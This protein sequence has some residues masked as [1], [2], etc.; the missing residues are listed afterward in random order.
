MSDKKN[1]DGRVIGEGSSITLSE[2]HVGKWV[3][4]IILYNGRE[5]KSRPVY[6]HGADSVLISMPELATSFSVD[7][8]YRGEV[9]PYEVTINSETGD[10][11][12]VEACFGEK[13]YTEAVYVEKGEGVTLNFE[14][15]PGNGYMN[16]SVKV[17]TSGGEVL[18][19][20]SDSINFL[21]PLTN[22]YLAP[23]TGKIGLAGPV[24]VD[25][26]NDVAELNTHRLEFTWATSETTKGKY[27]IEFEEDI[28][29][30]HNANTE[31]IAVVDYN[32]KLYNGR[33][34]VKNG[35]KTKEN[36]D[37]YTNFLKA[38][39]ERYSENSPISYFEIW[40][41]PNARALFWK[42]ADN[43]TDYVYLAEVSKRE[44][45]K[46][47]PTE[48]TAIGAAANGDYSWIGKLL[49]EGLYPN[50]DAVS[51]H[52]YIWNLKGINNYLVDEKYNDSLSGMTAQITRYGG[53]KEQIITEDNWSTFSGGISKEQ[54]AIEV[55]KAAVTADYYDIPT[56]QFYRSADDFVHD[57]YS[58]DL[59]ENNFGI[60]YH[61]YESLK[62]SA[63]SISNL[64][65]ETTGSVFAGKLP[66]ADKNIQAYLYARDKEITCVIWTKGNNTSVSFEGEV[67]TAT[68]INGNYIGE[69]SRFAIGESPVYIH[70]LS[71]K[72]IIN[73][74]SQNINDYIDLYIPLSFA[75]CEGRMGF[76][77]AKA[78]LRSAAQ[79]A[80]A[81]SEN[82][83]E[84]EAL[85]ALENHY[86]VNTG[87]I[88]M[89]KSGALDITDA[90]LNGLLYINQWGAN[91]L[92]VVYMLSADDGDYELSGMAKV[93]EAEGFI[94]EKAGEN[95]LSYSS[96]ILVYAEKFADKASG[97]MA[98]EGTNPQKAGATKAWDALARLIAKTARE[99]AE[100][101]STGYDNVIIQLPSSQWK[102]QAGVVN[103]IYV[104]AYNYRPTAVLNGKIELVSPS[105]T[106]LATSADFTINAQSSA[107]ILLPVSLNSLESGKYK[108]RLSENGKGIK[109]RTANIYM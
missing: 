77:E 101:E 33:Q 29:E 88:N 48:K 21:P 6:V 102:L 84:Q 54:H 47:N 75:S 99:M 12:T 23:F 62:P 31:I 94:K 80:D 51:N 24:A 69:G 16:T 59:P 44:L 63:F 3:R 60:F 64:C 70:G 11:Y 56:K 50:M 74:L 107:K 5:F 78:L 87:L 40:N 43:V 10:N 2:E 7:N 89:Y 61:G 98:K 13:T 17:K 95:T 83:T 86:S 45:E 65:Y 37:G 1:E 81:L 4:F 79:M 18:G 85:S 105:G 28:S 49:E 55:V 73:S 76:G 72:H 14:A 106:V 53:W 25:E 26:R 38:V 103:N 91:L 36:Q 41:E 82:L 19:E 42:E 71:K 27:N 66:F 58:K 22:A 92:S 57:T 9:Y 96:A 100:A 15:E 35:I 104:S 8:I 46:N 68:D 109:E 93:L 20:Y 108:I 67:L 34:S 97:L 32:N 52:P 39:Q 30:A 90:Q